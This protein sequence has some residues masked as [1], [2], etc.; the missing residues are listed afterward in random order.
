M[1]IL[2][3]YEF[4]SSCGLLIEAFDEADRDILENSCRFVLIVASG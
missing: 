1:E 4:A 3:V 2:C